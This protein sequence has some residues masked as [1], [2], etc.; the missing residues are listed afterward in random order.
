[1]LKRVMCYVLGMHFMLCTLISAA[2]TPPLEIG[3]TPFFTTA[4][5]MSTYEPLR[6]YLQRRLYRPVTL[7]TAPDHET[8]LKRLLQ[9]EYRFALVA[10]HYARM[11]Q[12]QSGYMPLLRPMGDLYG[13][14]VAAAT[15]PVNK[16]ADLKNATVALPD[17]LSLA[18]MLA[19]DT[20]TTHCLEAIRTRSYPSGSSAFLSVLRGENLAA[21]GSINNFNLLD[22][23]DKKRL[24]ILAESVRVPS[25]M[26]VARA[27]VP[28]SESKQM[29]QMFLDF[30]RDPQASRD[31]FGKTN[32][33]GFRPPTG[34]E[35]KQLDSYVKRIKERAWE[36]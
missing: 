12:L 4:Q 20:L 9:R 24:R 16:I 15:G 3:I 31:F 1:M 28:Q 29:A 17:P 14:L 30:A 21:F 32:Y 8:H 13:V 10:P 26:L 6:F 35:L 11:A 27:D 22:E 5:T 18:S 7:V 33:A 25:I 23:A 19:I 34:D 2:A 36:Q